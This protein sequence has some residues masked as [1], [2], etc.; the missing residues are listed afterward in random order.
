MSTKISEEQHTLTAG[1]KTVHVGH[2]SSELKP[3]LTINP[4]DT[5]L[6]ETYGSS[7]PETY[8][9][10]GVPPNMIPQSLRDIF[11]ETKDSGP[12]PHILTGPIQIN[13]AQTGDTLEV[14]IKDIVLTMPFG[15]NS[16]LWGSGALLEDFPYNS[17]RFLK[18]DLVKM[19]S[20]VI[21]GVIIPLRPFFGTLGVAPP[22]IMGRV[23]SM[24]PGI[25]GGNM[26]NKEIISGTVLYLPIHVKGA[27]FS[28]GDAH[29]V[30]G[31]GEVDSTALETSAKGTFQFFLHKNKRIKWPRAE[32]FTHFIAMGFNEDLDV[33]VQAAVREVIDFLGEVKGVKSEEAY[34]IASLAVDLRVTQVVNGVKGIHAMIPKKIFAC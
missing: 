12:G 32:S 6:I 17:K 2:L 27:Q 33:A 18:M 24:I 22:P 20:E 8:E 10:D 28:V 21:P 23:N 34:R 19:T 11:R 25:Y 7:P 16:I 3:V 29:A 14:R 31:D 13:G 1:P 15:Y 9:A 26:D 4:G 5:V 30:Q